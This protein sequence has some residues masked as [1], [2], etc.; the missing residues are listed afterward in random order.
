[1]KKINTLTNNQKQRIL[2]LACAWLTKSKVIIKG[3]KASEKTHCAELFSEM[4]GAD[5]LTYQMNQDLHQVYLQVKV[6]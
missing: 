4:L 6:Y 1:M 5:L 3:D 2:F